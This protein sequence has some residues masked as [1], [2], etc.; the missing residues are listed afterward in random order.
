MIKMSKK[1]K[2]LL[3]LKLNEF[4]ALVLDYAENKEPS[5]EKVKATQKKSKEINDIF[6]KYKLLK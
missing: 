2:E 4:K 3:E 1:D 5:E 6:R